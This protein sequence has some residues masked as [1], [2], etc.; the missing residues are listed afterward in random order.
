MTERKDDRLWGGRFERE[1]NAH[2]DAFQRSFAFDRR[3]LPYEIAV[4]RAWA[5]ALEPIGIFT[6]DR[7]ETNTSRARQNFRPRRKRSRVGR[8][9]SAQTPKTSTTSSK[10]PSSKNSARSAGSSIPA[11]AATSSWPP[12]FA[13]SSSSRGGNPA[14]FVRALE[15]AAM[16]A[17]AKISV[18]MAG[19][20]AYAACATDSALSFPYWRMRN[21]SFAT[22]RDCNTRSKRR[23][24]PDGFR[25]TR[26]K[27]LRH[28]P[29]CHRA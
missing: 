12:I 5:K 25:R 15:Y 17:K 27:L 22:S 9:L 21:P 8:T 2:F 11:A 20:D 23:R 13:S 4:D 28:R 1:P 18:P 26:R 6:V 14:W 24:L 19:H 3:L 7:S 10:K 29:Q 16:Q